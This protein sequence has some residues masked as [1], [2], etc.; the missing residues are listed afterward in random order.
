MVVLL[1]NPTLR[2]LHLQFSR[3]ALTLMLFHIIFYL[4]LKCFKTLLIAL[5]QLLQYW[6]LLSHLRVSN[7]LGIVVCERYACVQIFFYLCQD[8]R[9]FRF[10][11]LLVLLFWII[12]WN[13]VIDQ[14]QIAIS[15]MIRFEEITI[16][17]KTN[18]NRV[19]FQTLYYF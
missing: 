13:F 16:V 17:Q 2:L 5:K 12:Y 1:T 9:V 4:S 15:S 18:K 11:R 3:S 8:L 10:I 19:G 7:Y 14:P 6:L